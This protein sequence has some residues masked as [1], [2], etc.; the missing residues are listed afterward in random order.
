M[1]VGDTAVEAVTVVGL[2]TTPLAVATVD[3]ARMV[4]VET[5][6]TW[7]VIVAVTT[8]ILKRECKEREELV[9]VF[10]EARTT[11]VPRQ[12]TRARTRPPALILPPAAAGIIRSRTKRH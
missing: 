11:A 7:A 12:A 4:L 8:I 10:L 6:E 3:M 2:V 9:K 1:L 5:M